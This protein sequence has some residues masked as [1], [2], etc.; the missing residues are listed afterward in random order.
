MGKA[1]KRKWLTV[2]LCIF[3][4]A[5]VLVAVSFFVPLHPDVC[6]K[7]EH[8]GQEKCAARYIPIFIL[9]NVGKFLEDHEGA[10]VGIA[11]VF[12]AWFTYQLRAATV[13]LKDSTNRLW[14]AGE[15]QI[16]FV[17]EQLDLAKK[18]H[19]LARE[20]YFATHRPRVAVRRMNM[21]PVSGQPTTLSFTMVNTGEAAISHC[22]WNAQILLL[23]EV[24][25][26]HGTIFYQTEEMDRYDAPLSV[27]EGLTRGLK[28]TVTFEPAQLIDLAN[29]N[30][31]VHV[32]GYVAYTDTLD[33]TRRTGFFRYY[34]PG[35]R[36]FRPVDDPEYE[37]ED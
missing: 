18:Q 2:A 34:D 25:V 24:G 17:G 11:T 19:S 28:A 32:V 3:L 9:L 31:I 7:D 29:R 26:V 21:V 12:I 37:Y 14:E 20:E 13:G 36:R 1:E 30:I 4:V 8:S 16:A 6:S 5:S 35:R 23:S 22:F 15:K 33:V 27:G 10:I